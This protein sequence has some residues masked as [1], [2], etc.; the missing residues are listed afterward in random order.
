MVVLFY[1]LMVGIGD[2]V[3]RIIL[4]GSLILLFALATTYIALNQP[5][6]QETTQPTQIQADD[7]N[8]TSAVGTLR[9]EWTPE[10]EQAYDA[11]LEAGMVHR[12]GVNKGG[13]DIR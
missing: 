4:I 9:E 2:T 10:Q 13:F 7:P 5:T 3:K 6:T 12:N 1:Y 11:A 8:L